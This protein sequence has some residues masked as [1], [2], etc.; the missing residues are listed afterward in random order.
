MTE[1]DDGRSPHDRRFAGRLSH[2][3]AHGFG[4]GPSARILDGG[5]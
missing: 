3:G 5:D 2:Q 1:A 4:V